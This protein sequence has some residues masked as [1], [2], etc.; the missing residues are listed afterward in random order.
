MIHVIYTLIAWFE[1]AIFNKVVYN[2]MRYIQP[3]PSRVIAA[4]SGYMYNI[5][6][7]LDTTGPNLDDTHAGKLLKTLPNNSSSFIICTT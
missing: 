6:S 3:V 5:Y 2:I 7:P 4:I 1:D